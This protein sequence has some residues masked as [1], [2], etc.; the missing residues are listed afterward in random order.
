MTKIGVSGSEGPARDMAMGTT[1][2]MGMGRDTGRDREDRLL[3][4][5][6]SRGDSGIYNREK[7]SE[8]RIKESITLCTCSICNHV[9]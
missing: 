4:G 1:M 5:S 9:R 7:M 8:D 3:S 2:G 6:T